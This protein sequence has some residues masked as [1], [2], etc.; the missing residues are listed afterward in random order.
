M[1]P[2]ADAPLTLMQWLAMTALI[3]SALLLPLALLAAWWLRERYA[4]TVPQLQARLAPPPPPPV[5]HAAVPTTA[6]AAPA[7]PAGRAPLHIQRLAAADAPPAP[8]A[9]PARR[10]R[11]RVL[12]VQFVVGLLFWWL[13][14]LVLFT[15]MSMVVASEA[16]GDSPVGWAGTLVGVALLMLPPALAWALQAGLRE[17]TVWVALAVSGVVLGVATA[18]TVQT[19]FAETAGFIG[20]MLLLPLLASLFLRPAL[21]GAGPPLVAAA[22][23][24]W[25]AFML[26]CLGLVLVLPD[27]GAQEPW[28][29]QDSAGLAGLLLGAAV[30]MFW[31]GRR[32][33]RRIA[34]G[35]ASKQFSEQ[36]LALMAYWAL[37]CGLVLSLV[38]M[39]S[40][41][42]GGQSKDLGVALLLVLVAMALSAWRALQRQ[43]LRFVLRKA[44][45]PLPPLLLLRVFKPSNRSEAFMDRLLARWRFTAPVWLIAGPDLAGAFME[46]DEFFAWTQGTLG[47]RF[48]ADL[49][50][51]SERVNQIDAERDPDGRYRV[52]ELFCA[53]HVWQQTVQAL[54][55][56]AGVILLDLREYTEQ[57]AGTRFELELLLSRGGLD[58]LILLTDEAGEAP[59]M[60]AAVQRA[61]AA[62]GGSSPATLCLLQLRDGSDAELE[63]VFRAVAV[64]AAAAPVDSQPASKRA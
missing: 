57:R 59:L 8:A 50:Q 7:P 11:R 34:Q 17:R 6:A 63:G 13:M 36:Q 23:A 12:A 21:R 9:V 61:W 54:I 58:R 55:A 33:L 15:G 47:E 37:V 52:S 26:V 40:F 42:D 46:P 28:T 45:A 2:A 22:L 35:Y 4:R 5:D 25:A 24:G 56:R 3:F 49:A 39:V 1:T 44:P 38:L 60:Q 18:A 19:T 64:A 20:A 29:W 27:D 43:L 31:V 51:V 62:R 53:N 30:L 32:T 10:L 48:V 14:L 16:A 41:D